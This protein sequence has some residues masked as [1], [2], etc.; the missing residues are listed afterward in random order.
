VCVNRAALRM[1]GC[2]MTLP[3]SSGAVVCRE[4]TRIELTD[5]SAVT[6]SLALRVEPGHQQSCSIVLR[7]SMLR[8]ESPNGAVISLTASEINRPGSTCLELIDSTL[9][10]GRILAFTGTPCRTH[11]EAERSTFLF[12]QALVSFS[13]MPAGDAWRRALIWQGRENRYEA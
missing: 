9:E 7:S 10:G 13:G 1:R 12:R 6:D 3:C 4:A 5:C 8:A 2:R 11:V